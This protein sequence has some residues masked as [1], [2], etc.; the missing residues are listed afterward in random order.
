[1]KQLWFLKRVQSLSVVYG[2][3]INAPQQLALDF[4]HIYLC[5]YFLRVFMS[6]SYLF[7]C[8]AIKNMSSLREIIVCLIPFVI[9]GF[10]NRQ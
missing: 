9:W 7:S 8:F 4:F 6:F 3:F 2:L 5:A 1:M 10:I